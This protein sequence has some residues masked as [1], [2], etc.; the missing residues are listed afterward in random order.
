MKIKDLFLFR[1]SFVRRP[2]EN[3]DLGSHDLCYSIPEV[4]MGSGE[5]LEGQKME[6]QLLREGLAFGSGHYSGVE[7]CGGLKGKCL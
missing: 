3:T 1:A 2:A 5:L 4:N 6:S 7:T